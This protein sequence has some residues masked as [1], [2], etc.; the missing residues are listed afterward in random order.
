MAPVAVPEGFF[1]VLVPAGLLGISPSLLIYL[2][3]KSCILYLPEKHFSIFCMPGRPSLSA[4]L[5]MDCKHSKAKHHKGFKFLMGGCQAVQLEDMR[6]H[7]RKK[8]C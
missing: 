6:R 8:I 1:V 2:S 5:P 4:V 3:N 7:Y